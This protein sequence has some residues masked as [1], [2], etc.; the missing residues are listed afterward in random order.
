MS[1]GKQCDETLHKEITPRVFQGVL[2]PNLELTLPIGKQIY[3][4][5]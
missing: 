4:S 2:P 5:I 1:A 3:W